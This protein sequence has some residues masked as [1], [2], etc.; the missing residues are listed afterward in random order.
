MPYDS[1]FG[2]RQV[3]EV[4]SSIEEMNIS[5]GE[6]KLIFEDNARKLLRLPV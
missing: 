4:I 3:R 6:K 2:A 1:Q 5:D